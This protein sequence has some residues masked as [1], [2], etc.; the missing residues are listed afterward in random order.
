MDPTWDLNA[1]RYN[2]IPHHFCKS[3][4]EIRKSDSEGDG[5]DCECHRND[6]LENSKLINMDEET[7]KEVCKSLGYTRENG[8]FLFTNFR[9]QI[10]DIDKQSAS[11]SERIK[12]R[13]EAVQEYCPEFASCINSTSAALVTVMKST[14]NFNYNRCVINRVYSKSDNS[15][16]ANLFVYFELEDGTTKVYIADKNQG[17][18]IEMGM[19]EFEEQYDCYDRDKEKNKGKKLWES[20]EDIKKEKNVSSGEFTIDED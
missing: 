18:F 8:E 1:I 7:L 17:Q 20:T 2:A 6:E 14:E 4:E 13:L 16:K 15:K 19:K 3:Y 12:R 5:I 11:M 9:R 10:A